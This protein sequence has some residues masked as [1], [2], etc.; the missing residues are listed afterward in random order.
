MEFSESFIKRKLNWVYLKSRIREELGFRPAAD[1]V[2]GHLSLIEGFSLTEMACGRV[3]EIGSY[4]GRSAS[5]ICSNPQVWL[6]YC[7]DTWMNETMPEGKR[8]TYKEFTENVKS[9]GQIISVYSKSVDAYLPY[10]FDFIFIDGDHSY[11]TVI[12]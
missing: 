5:F 1:F 11:E 8:D 4:L 12:K 10:D 6:L 2:P 9:C 3:L 7:V